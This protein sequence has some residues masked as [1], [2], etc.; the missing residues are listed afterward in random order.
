MGVVRSIF[1][2]QRGPQ[3][4]M[5]DLEAAIFHKKQSACL[6]EA[7]PATEGISIQL[8]Y[9]PWKDALMQAWVIEGR[10]KATPVVSTEA[11][12]AS[13][14]VQHNAILLRS[15][16][17]RAIH[18]ISEKPVSEAWSVNCSRSVGRHSSP[19]MVLRHQG[20][21]EPGGPFCFEEVDNAGT[22]MLLTRPQ[23]VRACNTKLAE[24]TCGWAS[25][26]AAVPKA[27][28]TCAMATGSNAGIRRCECLA[29]QR[30]A[31]AN[32]R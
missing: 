6:Y 1:F 5:S 27:Q 26:M 32:Q 14:T 18:S 31:F 3:L 2:P 12:P 7:V 9:R 20:R 11:S 30:S 19:G 23:E 4:L 17:V 10:P 29:V 22:W 24:F 15:L 8:K 28:R 13:T 16:L 21:W 25:I